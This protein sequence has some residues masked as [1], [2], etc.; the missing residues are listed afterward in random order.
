MAVTKGTIDLIAT[1]VPSDTD[2]FENVQYLRVDVAGTLILQGYSGVPVSITVRAGET[3]RFRQGFVKVGTT[4]TVTVF[5][6]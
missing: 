6:G 3:I 4:A 1:V 5:G 2:S